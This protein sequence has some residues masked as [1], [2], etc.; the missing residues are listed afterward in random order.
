MHEQVN[1]AFRLLKLTNK[2]VGPIGADFKTAFAFRR[3]DYKISRYGGRRTD[4]DGGEDA[5]DSED[6]ID[7]SFSAAESLWSRAEDFW[8]LVGWAFNCSC[9]Q[10]TNVF[11]KR[12][13]RWS[14]WLDLML[15]VLEDDWRIRVERKDWAS[16][17]IWQYIHVESG[18]QARNR[19]IL[20]AIFADG[21]HRP[22]NEFREVFRNELK[23]PVKD[24]DKVKKREVDVNIEADIYGDYMGK[25]EDDF[26]DEE[27]A[28]A[29][30]KKK[31]T[32]ETSTRRATPRHSNTSLRSEYENGEK[33]AQGDGPLLLGGIESLGLRLRLLHLLSNVAGQLPDEFI[34]LDELYT[35][36]VEFIK[37]LPLPTFQQIVSPSVLPVFSPDAHTTLCEMLL[38]R[39]LEP[40]IPTLRTEH[41][42]TQSKMEK[43]YLPYTAN[44]SAPVENAKVSLLLE[45]LLRYLTIAGK[46]GF[47]P[48]LKKA[49]EDGNQARLD[50]AS[51][52]SRKGPKTTDGIAW[53]WLTESGERMMDIVA[54]LM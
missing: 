12:W 27:A 50:K 28:P 26:S 17:L 8:Q 51:S 37:P 40:S 21:G 38:Q 9:L 2:I 16:S 48:G 13:E 20:R 18:G 15:Q 42:L 5:A 29:V 49:V 19:R 54:R 31:K 43:C 14:L 44:K 25:D 39:I 6:K 1:A 3:F 7:T 30:F 22:L 11:A 34:P 52:S 46:L 24:A 23:E 41:F 47:R 36:F 32:R 35:L 10:D 45:S 4:G 53:A 33:D